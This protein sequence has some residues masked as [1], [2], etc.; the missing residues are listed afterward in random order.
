MSSVFL[1]LRFSYYE[2]IV[3]RSIRMSIH[4]QIFTSHKQFQNNHVFILRVYA[5]LEPSGSFDFSRNQLIIRF[6]KNKTT[7]NNRKRLR[8]GFREYKH[9]NINSTHIKYILSTDV[10]E[11]FQF[12]KNIEWLYWLVQ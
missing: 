6:C 4:F 12:Q 2:M 5:G 11:C 1:V 8:I 3:S 9:Q 7:K 10:L